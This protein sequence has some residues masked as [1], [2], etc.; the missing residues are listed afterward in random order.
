MCHIHKSDVRWKKIDEFNYIETKNFTSSIT[1]LKILIV[2]ENTCND[3][4]WQRKYL[5][6]FNK[7]V[8]KTHLKKTWLKDLNRNFSTLRICMA[9]G[10]LIRCQTHL[11]SRKNWNYQWYKTHVLNCKVWRTN[12]KCDGLNHIFLKRHMFKP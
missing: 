6:N 1:P 12:T 7:L 8:R 3:N 10:H 9:D 5:K 11:L 2:A 4:N